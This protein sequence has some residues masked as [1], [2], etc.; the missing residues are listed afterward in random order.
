[1]TSI[2]AKTSASVGGATVGG[3]ISPAF[4]RAR[5]LSHTSRFETSDAG[6]R[7]VEM[8]SG[9]VSLWHSEQTSVRMGRTSRSNASV[10][11]TET[12]FR[13]G[14]F[15]EGWDFAA[16]AAFRAGSVR[17]ARTVNTALTS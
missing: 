16:G 3:G 8:F 4:T 14:L 5:I 13:V 7:Y 10:N 1:M 15:V 12:L 9:A 2:N 17:A 11:E 6:S